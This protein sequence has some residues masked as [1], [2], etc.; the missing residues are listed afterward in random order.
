MTPGPSSPNIDELLDRA[1]AAINRGDRAA[2]D[3]LAGQVLAVD[4]GNTDAEDLL[5]TPVDG[6]EIRR[7]TMLFVDLVDSTALSTRIDVEVYRTV[8][9]S[10]RDLVL[11]VVSHY[12]GHIGSTKGDGLLAIFGHPQAHENDAHRAVHAGLDLTREVSALSARVRSRFGFDIDVRVGIHRGMIYLDTAQD[13]VY[14]LG[15]NLAARIC[16]LAEPGT[17][18]VSAAIQKVVRDEFE[19]QEQSPKTVKGVDGPVTYYR[20]LDER[21]LASVVRGPLVGR[22][23]EHRYL[24]TCWAQAQSGTLTPPG[25]A[26]TGEGG[27]G[28]SRLAGAAVDLAEK[29]GAVVL[30]LFGSPFHTEVGLRPV[31]RLLEIRCG[32][33]RGADRAE[34]LRLLE[35]EIKRR[36]MDPDTAVPLLAPVI[37]IGPGSGY[38]PATASGGRLYERIVGT[39]K[40]YLLACLSTGPGLV[41]IEDFH[42]LDEDTTEVVRA[43][44]AEGLTRTLIVITDRGQTSMNPA[45]RTFEL[46][47]LRDD[48]ADQLIHALHPQ[49][50]AAAR[51]A[52]QERCDGIPLYIEEVVAKLKAQPGDQSGSAQVPDTLY[53]ALIARL[54]SSR[55]SLQVIEISA[56]LG[57][58]IDRRLLSSVIDTDEESVA[59]LLN[60]LARSRVLRSIDATSWRFH[61][62]LL[63]E[64]AAE[65]VPPTLRRRLH[66]R[67]ADALVTIAADSP[68]EWPLVAHHYLQADRFAEAAVSFQK[69]GANARHRGALAEALTH[70]SHALDC[71]SRLDPGRAR[72]RHEIEIRLERG[73]LTSVAHG[74]AS[75]EAA[76]EFERC[77]QLIGDEASVELYATLSALWSYYATRGDLRRAT[78]LVTALRARRGDLPDWYRVANDSVAGSLAMFRGDFHTARATLEST[79]VAI[80]RLG[81]RDIE[82]A[83]FAPNDPLAGA[84]SLVGFLRFIQGDLTAAESAFAEIESRCQRLGFPH[85]PF[86]LCY[87]RAVE[88]LTRIE[89][90]QLDRAA[91][92]VA[93]V[94]RRG[95]A[96]GFDEWVMIAACNQASVGARML[97]ATGRA[98]PDTLQEHIAANTAVVDGWRAAG[99]KTFLACYDGVLARVLIAAGMAEA[100]RDRIDL[101]LQMAEDT[102]IHFYD[103]E[104]LRIRAHT[105]DDRLTKHHILTKATQLARDQGAYTFE[106]RC[107]ADDVEVFGEPAR[108]SLHQAL[109]R[110]PAE[111]SWPDLARARTLLR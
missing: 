48:E 24:K 54:Q 65:L 66:S 91:A 21:D 83:W 5:S 71:T 34:S 3:A 51:R 69:A 13:D 32:I 16:S 75:P 58:R 68:P 74:H 2:A 25:V 1:V 67:I 39:V 38:Q 4:G 20:V 108:E 14:G 47:P 29:S 88:T 60:G 43:L 82:D 104:L 87:A 72:D 106:L 18:A 35:A 42:W 57:S 99:T 89:A 96:N 44:L 49:L 85:G 79:I 30:S 103:A 105:Y 26:F 92:L 63:R 76:A 40:E 36:S 111:Q 95:E 9:G 94:A 46:T 19:F 10:Y 110:F 31:R 98:G 15:V 50:A 102:G 55:N 27:I 109:S 101:A 77:L 45:V 90:G 22:T 28:K 12:A 7:L 62:E 23:R 73:F 107:A 86:T 11:E 8:V 61:H 17:V 52:V 6:G 56:L 100:G 37:G 70:L 41:L 53:E 80:D 93:E 64:V 78:Q 84:Y 59:E 81:P 97:L 33:S